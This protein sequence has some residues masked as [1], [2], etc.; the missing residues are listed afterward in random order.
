MKIDGKYHLRELHSLLREA[1]FVPDKKNNGGTHHKWFWENRLLKV[2]VV[3]GHSGGISDGLG[4]GIVQTILLSR[5][6][7]GG[8]NEV[9]RFVKEFL[10]Q[11]KLDG[12]LLKTLEE[13]KSNCKK[14]IMLYF[15]E[16]N[17]A[18][19]VKDAISKIESLVTAYHNQEGR[20]PRDA[21]LIIKELNKILDR[22]RSLVRTNQKR[23]GAIR[24]KPDNKQFKYNEKEASEVKWSPFE[25]EEIRVSISSDDKPLTID[26]F[27]ASLQENRIDVSA[28]IDMKNDAPMEED[29]C[30]F[31]ND[32]LNNAFAEGDAEGDVLTQKLQ[33]LP[34]VEITMTGKFPMQYDM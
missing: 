30:M 22:E 19:S 17:H 34:E 21:D 29:I 20:N 25:P 1:D 16:I 18:S 9:E 32:M 13:Q 6:V 12:D 23:N 10:K 5:Y 4:K 3:E 2:Q 15:S 24:P 28:V 11:E 27:W 33:I 31:S 14:N 8:D 26:D 7:I